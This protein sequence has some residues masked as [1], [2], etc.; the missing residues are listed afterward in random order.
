MTGGLIIPLRGCAKPRWLG[1]VVRLVWVRRVTGI[2]I[3]LF[4]VYTL[5]GLG[6]HAVHGGKQAGHDCPAYQ[7]MQQQKQ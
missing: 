5:A 6:G 3:L 4:G 2:L 7:S 1:N